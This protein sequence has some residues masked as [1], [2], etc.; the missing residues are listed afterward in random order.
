M[1]NLGLIAMSSTTS[2]RD[3]LL[4]CKH[5]YCFPV[6]GKVIS[7]HR[8]ISEPPVFVLDKG[9]FFHLFFSPVI[10]FICTKHVL[11]TMFSNEKGFNTPENNPQ[12][13]EVDL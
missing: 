3:I 13:C 7:F 2:K 4:K 6:V 8:C 10:F 5:K 9:S 1:K 12:Y 11:F